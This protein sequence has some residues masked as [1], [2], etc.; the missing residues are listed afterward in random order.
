[1]PLLALRG[2][3]AASIPCWRGMSWKGASVTVWGDM[4]LP[5]SLIPKAVQACKVLGNSTSGGEGGIRTHGGDKP[6]PVFKTGAI[7]HSTT[8]PDAALR[9]A[10]HRQREA[11]CQEEVCARCKSGLIPV[12]GAS[13]VIV[14]DPQDR[15]N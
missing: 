4:S 13:M 15:P 3:D 11:D 9:W 7:N 2:C 8:S 5:Y 10:D 1:M 14:H 12:E 6:T